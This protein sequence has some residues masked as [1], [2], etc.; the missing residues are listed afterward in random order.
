MLLSF[1]VL[2]L[3]VSVFVLLIKRL[4]SISVLLAVM[5]AVRNAKKIPTKDQPARSIS[6]EGLKIQKLR[7]CSSK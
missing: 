6:N 2:G 4:I 3:I 7:N 1:I 5:S